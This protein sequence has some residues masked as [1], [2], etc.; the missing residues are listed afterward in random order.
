MRPPELTPARFV[1]GGLSAIAGVGALAFG[2]LAI[3]AM[4]INRLAVKRARI[5]SLSVG[6][7]EV[8]RLIIRDRIDPEEA[9]EARATPRRRQGAKARA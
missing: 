2:A 9:A 7:L 3:G 6:T 1:G 4:A 5:E 8:D